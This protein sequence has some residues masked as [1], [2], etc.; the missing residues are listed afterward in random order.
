VATADQWKAWRA[1]IR[2]GRPAERADA[3]RRLY[4]AARSDGRFA[5]PAKWDIDP[6]TLVDLIHEVLSVRWELIL[7]AD[8]PR[9]FFLVAVKRKAIDRF[10]RQVRHER[11]GEPGPKDLPTAATLKPESLEAVVQ[12]D[13]V[14]AYLESTSSPRDLRVFQASTMLGET[15]KAI[16]SAERLSPA[17]VDQI[18]SRTRKRLREHFDAGS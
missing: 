9:A 16:A 17:N 10:R 5:V 2:D 15:S 3:T 8:S 7:E 12:L 11:V 6:D 13:Q 4:D 1:E 14:L 18:V